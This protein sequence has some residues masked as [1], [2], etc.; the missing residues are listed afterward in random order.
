MFENPR[1]GRQARNLKKKCLE[2]SRSQMAF[3]TDIFRKLTLGAPVCTARKEECPQ[4]L[5]HQ[6]VDWS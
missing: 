2:N 3:R 4:L 6:E 1:K 5:L